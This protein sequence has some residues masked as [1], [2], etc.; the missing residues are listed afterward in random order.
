MS[1]STFTMDFTEVDA[2]ATG[3]C[4]SIISALTPISED[5]LEPRPSNQKNDHTCPLCGHGSFFV[6]EDVDQ[7]GRVNCHR[8]N[9]HTGGPRDTV[10]QFGGFDS[11]EAAE[12]IAEYLGIWSAEDVGKPK[13]TLPKLGIVEA[14]SKAKRMPLDAFR[15]FGAKPEKRKTGG[16][17]IEVARVPFWNEHG[18]MFSYCDLTPNDKALNKPGKG[19]T[20]LFLPGRV[21]AAGETWHGVEG[22]KDAAALTGLG[23]LA[24]GYSGSQLNERFAPLFRGAN[25]VLVPDLDMPGQVGA[26]KSGGRLFGI[27]ESVRVARLPGEILASK[28][29]D[30]R[31]I[32]LTEEGEAKVRDA[33]AN[34][35][36]W[37]PDPVGYADSLDADEIGLSCASET[38]P[39]NADKKAQG[40]QD[41]ELILIDGD[42]VSFRFR[43]LSV[44]EKF[45]ELSDWAPSLP[46]MKKEFLKQTHRPL[47]MAVC[48]KWKT[49]PDR[50]ARPGVMTVERPDASEDYT[51]VIASAVLRHAAGWLSFENAAAVDWDLVG[52]RGSIRISGTVYLHAENLH[53]VLSV[54]DRMFELTRKRLAKVLRLAGAESKITQLG[55]GSTATR[56]RLWP[57]STTNIEKLEGIAIGNY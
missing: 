32:L 4:K 55:N 10:S 42:P 5:I 35:S 54:E 38:P 24:F 9:I 27:A 33:I 21:P 8:C 46:A 39:G 47:P 25:V 34:A 11:H 29:K 45:C 53:S 16:K 14:V 12:R 30:V 2:E 1:T 51:C 57:L 26:Q 49:L 23:Y 40:L 36:F 6:D 31:D 28:G 7:H 22:V 18:E 37:K 13:P 20:G 41:C 44:S 52:R 15:K 17:L 50:L 48:R 3:R 56:K 43:C 19:N